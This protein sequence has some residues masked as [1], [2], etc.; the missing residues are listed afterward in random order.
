MKAKFA[1]RVAKRHATR[2]LQRHRERPEV[3]VEDRARANP[4]SLSAGD[5]SRVK[6]KQLTGI[7]GA[8][9]AALILK[10]LRQALQRRRQGQE[11]VKLGRINRHSG[12]TDEVQSRGGP[13]I[14][15]RNRVALY[16]PGV[17]CGGL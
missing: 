14:L 10:N 12:E 16:C 17:I 11:A 5:R 7:G 6:R 15:R 3:I 8:Q 1:D 9:S 4:E 13:T 2:R